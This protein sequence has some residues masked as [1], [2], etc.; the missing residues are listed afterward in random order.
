MKGHVGNG[1]PTSL[2]L[3]DGVL[4]RKSVADLQATQKLIDTAN[5]NAKQDLEQVVQQVQ[6]VKR[7]RAK[8]EDDFSK[9]R[10][11][12]GPA[13]MAYARAR[14]KLLRGNPENH[15]PAVESQC[16]KAQGLM[17]ALT[18]IGYKG[19]A[20]CVDTCTLGQGDG[21]GACDRSG[22]HGKLRSKEDLEAVL[23]GKEWQDRH[24]E[25]LSVCDTWPFRFNMQPPAG[26]KAE[27][28]AAEATPTEATMNFREVCL[29]TSL[30]NAT[31][32]GLE[33]RGRNGSHHNRT[34]RNAFL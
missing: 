29:W 23:G 10:S 22:C 26:L 11:Q 4:G 2:G 33:P 31:L 7:A 24:A 30:P 27:K 1:M 5:A 19:N 28:S 25:V 15:Q 32:R 34:A 20:G 12:L 8:L 6:E 21:S 3:L 9:L 14:L 18:G 17:F 16:L 13:C